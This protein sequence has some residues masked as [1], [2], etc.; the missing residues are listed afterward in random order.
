V[1]K[2]NGGIFGYELGNDY[3]SCM[4]YR[5]I[6]YL[7]IVIVVSMILY[8]IWEVIK[9]MP[10]DHPLVRIYNWVKRIFK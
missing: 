10:E 4:I 2:I 9:R 7:V 3:I 5:I 1:D 8:V 6:F